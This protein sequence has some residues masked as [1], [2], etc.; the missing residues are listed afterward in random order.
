MKCSNAA[1]QWHL[2]TTVMH[3]YE[4][5]SSWTGMPHLCPALL[6]GICSGWSVQPPLLKLWSNPSASFSWH[7]C[8]QGWWGDAGFIISQAFFFFLG[9][10][11]IEASCTQCLCNPWAV[12]K[13]LSGTVLGL[14][15]ILSMMLGSVSVLQRFLSFIFSRFHKTFSVNA[16]FFTFTIWTLWLLTKICVI[17]AHF[18]RWQNDRILGVERDP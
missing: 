14:V 9:S 2:A 18:L 8:L 3:L 6:S 7:W 12:Q 13:L 17:Q 11:R 10:S 1:L 15:S 5:Y 16:V 4:I